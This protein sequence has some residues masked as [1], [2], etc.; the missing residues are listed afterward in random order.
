VQ[1]RPLSH[2]KQNKKMK[3]TITTLLFVCAML[4]SA[5]AQTPDSSQLAVFNTGRNI[6]LLSTDFGGALTQDL[7][8]DMVMAYD[9]VMV[10]KAHT[11]KDSSGKFPMR[12][13]TERRATKITANLKDKIA[14]IDFNKDY[15]VTQMCLNAQRAGAKAVI[16]IHESNDKKVYKL[17]KKGLY[18]DSIRIPCFTIPNKRGL[19]IQELLPSVVG[20]KKPVLTTQQLLSQLVLSLSAVA[21]YN[22]SLVTWVN[23][24]GTANDFFVVQKLNRIT[25]E[26]EN[27]ATINSQPLDGNE[28]YTTYDTNP[29]DGD[30]TYRIKL[31][32][33]DGTIRYSEDKTVV[34]Y[35]NSGIVLFPNPADDLLNI[36]FKGYLGQ[37]VDMTLFDMQGKRI[38][39]KHIDKL[40]NETQTLDISD[41]TVVGQYLIL[42]QSKG[43]R[44][45]CAQRGIYR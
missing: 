5:T 30:N 31:V 7:I 27:L 13:Q 22:K 25:G 34:F 17:G 39:S 37:E 12:Y 26:Y 43:V 11:A 36:G 21:E 29:I 19:N 16:I 45:T 23:N 32:L 38:F 28:N 3:N 42:I 9:T 18:K 44:K 10:L 24:T 4:Q 35:S 2:K 8:G 6:M 40:Q 33:N 15:D 14:V 41:K 20:I 1:K